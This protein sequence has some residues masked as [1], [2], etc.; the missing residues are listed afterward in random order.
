VSFISDFILIRNRSQNAAR[1]PEGPL[2]DEEMELFIEFMKEYSNPHW[3]GCRAVVFQNVTDG[4]PLSWWFAFL[5]SCISRDGWHRKWP[6]RSDTVSDYLSLFQKNMAAEGQGMSESHLMAT[7]FALTSVDVPGNVAESGFETISTLLEATEK[8]GYL[9]GYILLHLRILLL[10]SFECLDWSTKRELIVNLGGRL[11]LM[12]P[13]SDVQDIRITS[14]F[15][16]ISSQ[17]DTYDCVGLGCAL[18]HAGLDLLQFLWQHFRP[19]SSGHGSSIAMLETV[20]GRVREIEQ[21]EFVK[22]A[23]DL[24]HS[25]LERSWLTDRFLTSNPPSA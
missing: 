8:I 6:N 5:A 15:P 20:V 11:R 1:S 23:F 24:V 13:L 2:S 10:T 21:L 19:E 16:S 25:L 7:F 3:Q 4:Q 17:K 14:C 18:N 12:D 22:S 9:S